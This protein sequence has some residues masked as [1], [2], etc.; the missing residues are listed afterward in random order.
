MRDRTTSL[1]DTVNRNI[2][3]D[4]GKIIYNLAKREGYCQGEIFIKNLFKMSAISCVQIFQI[5]E[6][7]GYLSVF[8]LPELA[9]DTTDRSFLLE[10]HSLLGS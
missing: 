1:G 7:S 4:L 2:T 8:I 3:K 5:A 6:S 10:T 9:F